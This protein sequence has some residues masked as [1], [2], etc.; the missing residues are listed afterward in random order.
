MRV[1]PAPKSSKWRV[2]TFGNLQIEVFS[3]FGEV[4]KRRFFTAPEGSKWGFWELWSFGGKVGGGGMFF[5]T[6]PPA[7]RSYVLHFFQYVCSFPFRSRDLQESLEISG[8]HLKKNK[9]KEYPQQQ[10]LREKVT[11]CL[12]QSCLRAGW[13]K[14][15]DCVSCR[16]GSEVINLQLSLSQ[17]SN[18]R[19]N[20]PQ[21]PTQSLNSGHVIAG[22]K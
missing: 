8:N 2:W 11:K 13:G 19:L 4:P 6:P 15:Y 3:S 18:A 21:C 7:S 1:F 16:F 20:T 14:P 22:T 17:F 10:R 12:S 5:F 9:P